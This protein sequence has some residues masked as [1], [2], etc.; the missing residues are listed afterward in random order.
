M[1][2]SRRDA[3][4]RLSLC[5]SLA[6]FAAASAEREEAGVRPSDDDWPWWRGPRWDGVAVGETPPLTWSDAENVLW[7]T[8]VPGRGHSTPCIHGERIFLT[9]AD[10]EKERQSV[11]CLNRGDGRVL[12][13]RR[14]HEGGFGKKHRKNSHAS[15][16]PACDGER[17]FVVFHRHAA[18]WA[19]AL[20]L[21]SETVWE[22]RIGDYD[23]RYGY[24]SSPTL[25]GDALIV[26][27]DSPADGFLVALDRAT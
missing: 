11:L 20:D 2:P 15:A 18:L 16:T 21:A 25:H 17:T 13:N 6:P 3:L 14:I 7:K 10:E 12:W 27:G 24:G 23:D 4:K 5:A 9:T 19:T 8:P 26:S 1:N 22:K